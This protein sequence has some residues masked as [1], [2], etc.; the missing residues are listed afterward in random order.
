MYI[1]FALI[2]TDI[3]ESD[4]RDRIKYV[5]DRDLTNSISVPFYFSKL[6]KP[7]INNG[8]DCACLIDYPLGISDPTTRLSAV[9]QAIKA[10]F[11]TLD[12]TMPQNLASNRKYDK[13]RED[14]Q[15]IVELKADS[16]VNIRYILEYRK[17][18]HHCLK[19]ICEIFEQF[20]I[21]YIFPSSGY[22]IDNIA[23]N[24]LA[25]IF[26]LKNSKNI[27]IICTGNAWRD[28]HYETIINS[29]LFGFRTSSVHTLENFSIY[30][31]LRHKKYGV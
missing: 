2:D 9:A 17:F 31:L 27:K 20:N 28:Q 7:Y 14:I 5:I 6:L 22:F 30:N 19:K 18:D 11:N 12:I 15:S 26:L 10:G 3:T 1:D 16:K 23:D 24:I 25:S 13:I 21:E 4:A 8:L 29:G